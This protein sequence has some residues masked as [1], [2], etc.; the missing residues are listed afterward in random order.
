MKGCFFLQRRFAPIGCHIA[1]QLMKYGVDEFCIY[2][3]PR[4]AYQ[5]L[6]SQKDL[7]ITKILLDEDIY[8]KYK[9][10]KLDFEYLKWLEKEYGLPNL[11]H[12]LYIDRV[13][14]HSQL[15]REY[16]HDQPLLS[17]EDMLRVL[18]VTSKEIIKFLKEE[19][20]DF[21]FTSVVGSTASLLLYHICKKMGVKILSL[22]YSRIKNGII[23]TEDYRTFSW[24]NKIFDEIQ[25]GKIPNPKEKEAKQF[26]EEFR[27][28]PQSYYDAYSPD[29]LALTTLKQFRFLLP[30]RFVKLATWLSNFFWKNLQKKEKDYTDEI[31][32]YSIWDKIK[33]K[34]RMLRGYSDLYSA[35]DT[36]G[37]YAFYGLHYEPEIALFLYAPFWNDQINLIKQIAKSLPINFKLLVKEHPS[38]VGYR[39]RKYY[40][41]LLKIPN[42]QLINPNIAGLN[43]IKNAKLV[44]SI[45]GG[46]IWEAIF[47][48][49]PTITFAD[50]WFNKLSMVKRSDNIE[51][52]PYLVK[53]QLEN[54][55]HDDRELINFIGAILEDSVNA[56][57]TKI[58]EGAESLEAIKHEKGFDDLA[59]LIAKKV[60]L[61]PV[62]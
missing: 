57:L 39:P 21:L 36:Q 9:N 43:L 61:L 26:L 51:K 29:N 60:G 30:H 38:M 35:P 41:E 34:V 62:K 44:F 27:N 31:F 6:S 14:M 48:K 4:T 58:R 56:N 7:P 1:K 42:I 32:W 17:Y 10:E 46:A 37:D 47:L 45:S 18:Q 12:Y 15:I 5:F 2:T 59:R 24:A 8:K 54:F 23:L 16:P 53:E 52:L 20:P 55:R 25:S 50:V 3:T 13:I 28:N 22:N 40:K 33:R 11:W 49:K 19:K